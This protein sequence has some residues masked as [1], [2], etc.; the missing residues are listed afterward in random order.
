[1]FPRKIPEY[2]RHFLYVSGAI[3]LFWLWDIIPSIMSNTKLQ[4]SGIVKK[5][6]YKMMM[7]EKKN[8]RTP[9]WNMIEMFQHLLGHFIIS[10]INMF[11]ENDT[12]EYW[13]IVACA[14]INLEM[15]AINVYLVCNLK[16][17]TY[18]KWLVCDIEPIKA[19]HTHHILPNWLLIKI[20]FHFKW[21]M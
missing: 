21:T 8:R 13:F 3:N 10:H 17:G 16:I 9:T 2:S 11:I 19:T 14:L 20:A 4:I 18:C 12:F 1:M 6:T 7:D 15:F 5:G